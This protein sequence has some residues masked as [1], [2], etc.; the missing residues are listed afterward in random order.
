[1]SEKDYALL[2]KIYLEDGYMKPK[3][4]W[5]MMIHTLEDIIYE[6]DSTE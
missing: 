4:Y 3:K 6:A 5:K 2:D 1:M